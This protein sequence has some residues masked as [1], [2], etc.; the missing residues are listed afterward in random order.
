MKR[1]PLLLVLMLALLL[2]AALA[3]STAI[4]TPGEVTETLFAEA[5]EISE[6]GKQPKKEQLAELFP[7]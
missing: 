6:Y 2:P 7:L 5:F 1:I 4:Y 3:E